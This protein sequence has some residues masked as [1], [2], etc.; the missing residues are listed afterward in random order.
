MGIAN[1]FLAKCVDYRGITTMIRILLVTSCLVGSVELA[2][3]Q[4]TAKL[5]RPA[6]V[7]AW[8]RQ[9]FHREPD[10]RA[11]A[12]WSYLFRLGRTEQE[13]L[14]SMLSTDEYYS[15]A[16]R[17]P[18]GLVRA[19]FE[20][21]AQNQLTSE[22][23]Q[24]LFSQRPRFGPPE[25][26]RDVPPDLSRR[27]SRGTFTCW[28]HGGRPSETRQGG[29]GAFCSSPAESPFDGSDAGDNSTPETSSAVGAFS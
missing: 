5:S 19:L 24:A 10:A 7:R 23:R 29:S 27:R 28:C 11:V 3:G 26:S 4:T 9:Y 20:D 16:G 14:S 1:G 21:G 22:R 2:N 6:L 13:V 15:R 25:R 12:S 8:H 17:T 18:E